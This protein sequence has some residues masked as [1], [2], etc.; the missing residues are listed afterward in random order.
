MGGFLLLARQYLPAAIPHLIRQRRYFMGTFGNLA[1]N[2]SGGRSGL[3]EVIMGVLQNRQGGLSGIISDF[4]QNG[5]GDAVQSWIGTGPNQSISG[6]QA[7]QVLGP[8]AVQQ[9]A[10]QA[11]ISHE[12][13]KSHL[14]R[15]VPQIVDRLTPKGQ[16]PPS[17]DLMSQGMEMLKSKLFG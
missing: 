1:Q 4:Q 6:E 17:K 12:E 9:V 3:A 16:V 14:A 2:L 5:M 13:A 8:A 7:S 10:E 15:M 11:G